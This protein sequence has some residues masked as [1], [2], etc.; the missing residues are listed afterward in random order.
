MPGKVLV[1]DSDFATRKNA[2]ATLMRAGYVVSVAEDPFAAANVAAQERPDLVLLGDS[3]VSPSGLALVGR[4]F[5]SA[6]TAAM[7]VLVIADTPERQVAADQAGPR[8]VLP[9]PVSGPDLI[10][11]VTVQIVAPGALQ[12]APASVLNDAERLAA[13]DALR[14]DSSGQ[15]GLDRFTQLASKML[16]VPVS[17]I[18]LIDKDR[19]VYASHVGVGEPWASVGHAPLEYSYCQYA[20][21]SRQPLRIDDATLHPLVQNSPAISELD[22]VSYVGIPLITDDDQAVGT[23]CVVDSRPRHWTDHEV[24]ILNDLAGIL[25]A[26]LNSTRR[27]HGRHTAA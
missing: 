8:A 1:V 22:A 13:V 16:Q 3:M 5:S 15:A 4:F 9:G 26:Q 20:V 10:D 25:T 6:A 18:T 21:T 17:T 2:I 24:G 19:Q 11:A 23:L 7:P 12:Q 14:P 27:N